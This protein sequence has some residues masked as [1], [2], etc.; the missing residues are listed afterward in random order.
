VIKEPPGD[1]KRGNRWWV[2]VYAGR[3]PLTGKKRQK[4]GTAASKAE[5]RQL[6][7]RLISRR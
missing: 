1:Q 5:A 6:E 7:A 3:D 4:T 2:V